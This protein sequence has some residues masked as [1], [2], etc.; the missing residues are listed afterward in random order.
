MFK[1]SLK[2]RRTIAGAAA[3]VAAG[4]AGWALA[5]WA[6]PPPVDAPQQSEPA[7]DSR[8][9]L[10]QRIDELLEQRLAVFRDR[11]SQMVAVCKVGRVTQSRVLLTRL[12]ALEAELPIC[13]SAAERVPIREKIVAILKAFADDAEVD[14]RS[15]PAPGSAE[16]P[17]PN[18]AYLLAKTRVLQAEID[19]AKER[20]AALEDAK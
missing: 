9:D 10:E 16:F 11:E 17:P 4:L 12:D 8:H 20:L 2:A 13:R 6:A 19:L 15:P 5:V 14:S 18:D 1:P 7:S 3:L